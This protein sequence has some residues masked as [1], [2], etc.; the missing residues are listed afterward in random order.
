MDMDM[1]SADTT[2]YCDSDTPMRIYSLK[3]TIN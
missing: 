1:L 2:L 3:A